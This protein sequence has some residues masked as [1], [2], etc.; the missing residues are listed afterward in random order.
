ML[1]KRNSY[2]RKVIEFYDY[3]YAGLFI[4]SFLAATILPLSSEALLGLMLLAD[5]GIFPVI[6]WA[7]FGNWL[8]GMSSYGLGYLGKW[9]WL[10]K[11]FKIKMKHILK[12]Q[13]WIEKYGVAMALFCWMPVV[14]DAIAV[15]L[16]FFKSK[17]FITSLA[18]FIGKLLRY[19]II[20]L[21]ILSF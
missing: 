9:K 11:Y 20:S 5:Y 19:I 14:G 15:G 13:K 10:K 1:S 6:F 21:L 2:F 3:G 7:S 18:M 17:I 4:A 12:W 8:G 16:G